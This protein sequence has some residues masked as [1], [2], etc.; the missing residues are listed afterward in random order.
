M[1]S[2]PMSLLAQTELLDKLERLLSPEDRRRCQKEA[3]MYAQSP[4]GHALQRRLA[5]KKAVNVIFDCLTSL[6]NDATECRRD[7]LI[8]D[9]FS[10]TEGVVFHYG[11]TSADESAEREYLTRTKEF[12][13]SMLKFETEYHSQLAQAK[14]ELARVGLTDDRLPDFEMGLGVSSETVPFEFVVSFLGNPKCS[15]ECIPEYILELTQ[16]AF[17][18][19]Q[20][21]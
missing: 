8:R 1:K 11:K 6:R 20:R 10:P 16:K 15:P 17:H 19:R 14:A 5:C 21:L 4:N 3:T 12:R 13:T 2:S 9:L 7:H 18:R